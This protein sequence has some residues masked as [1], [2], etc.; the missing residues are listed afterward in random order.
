[1][2]DLEKPIVSLTHN[3]KDRQIVYILMIILQCVIYGIGNPITKIA[4]ESI[5]PFWC[6]AFRF[7]LAALVIAAIAGKR[8]I[9]EL[10]SVRIGNWMPGA[11]CMAGAYILSNIALN[12]TTATMVGFL[13][14]LPVIFVPI[15]AII[16]LHRPYRWS[17]LPVQV[18]AAAGLYLLCS[19]GGVFSFGWGEALALT[20]AVCTAGALVWGEKSLQSL[21]P[22]TLSFAQIVITAVLSIMGALIFERGTAFSAIQPEAWW[23]IVYLA[24]FCSCLSYLL[25]NIALTHI[26]S[27]L[28]SLTQCTEPVFTAAASFAILGEQL[29]G[30]G[31]WGAALLL[32]CIVYGNYIEKKAD[33]IL[34]VGPTS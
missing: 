12:L 27:S 4:Y 25:Q 1:M 21:S 30:M 31:W 29:S 26:P 14:S 2:D 22:L 5:T 8:A 10:R 28:I 19:T 13:M 33:G 9:T 15:L 11:L 24:V 20:V 17:F 16:V 23:V 6:L 32:A 7:T 34:P 3:K 18:T